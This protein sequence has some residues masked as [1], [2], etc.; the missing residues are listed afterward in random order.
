MADFTF[1]GGL[2]RDV[3][4]ICVEESHFD[5]DYFGGPGV[6]VTPVVKGENADVEIEAFVTKFEK[7]QVIRFSI[8]DQDGA[9]VA[10]AEDEYCFWKKTSKLN[11]VRMTSSKKGKAQIS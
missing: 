10:K 11:T 1:Y 9:E 6:K 2:Y 7:G 4:V 5:L 3:N 8:W